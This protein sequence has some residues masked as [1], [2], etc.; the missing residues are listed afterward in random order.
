MKHTPTPWMFEVVDGMPMITH[1]GDAIA[2]RTYCFAR[3][4]DNDL[5]HI[6]KCVNAHNGLVAV[7]KKADAALYAIERNNPFEM[8]YDPQQ[9]ASP[10]IAK[11]AR[12]ELK[13]TLE[14]LKDD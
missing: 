14:S 7:L 2:V 11:R 6:V 13:Q 10:L 9:Q 12:K 8:G 3:S 4:D 1:D 5:E